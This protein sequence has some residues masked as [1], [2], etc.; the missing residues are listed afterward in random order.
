MAGWMPTGDLA[1]N[2]F[3]FVIHHL[4]LTVWVLL[5]YSIWEMSWWIWYHFLAICEESMTIL[6]ARGDDFHDQNLVSEQIV[7]VKSESKPTA[8]APQLLGCIVVFMFSTDWVSMD[9]INWLNI[10]WFLPFCCFMDFGLCIF[11][12]ESVI[13][14]WVIW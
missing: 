3:T 7:V 12:K 8:N 2:F 6:L 1:N 4:H 5:I 9:I 10:S 13:K 14:V 11:S